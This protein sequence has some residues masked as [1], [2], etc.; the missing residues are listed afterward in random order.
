MLSVIR[1]NERE[2]SADRRRAR[3]RESGSLIREE[4]EIESKAPELRQHLVRSML[5]CRATFLGKQRWTQIFADSVV[6]TLLGIV[7]VSERRQIEL[8][9]LRVA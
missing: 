7:P 5:R 3:K 4:A 8:H 1:D 2:A 9:R 6:L